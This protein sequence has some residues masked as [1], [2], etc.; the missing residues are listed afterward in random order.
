MHKR[1]KFPF[2]NDKL[3]GPS[4]TTEQSNRGNRFL[5]AKDLLPKLGLLG[6]KSLR[7]Y[8]KVTASNMGQE[9]SMAEGN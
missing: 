4:K 2:S 8:A 7:I 1:K 5:A 3:L 6:F 9:E